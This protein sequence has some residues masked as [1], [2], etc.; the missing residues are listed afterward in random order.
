MITMNTITS[1]SLQ[2]KENLKRLVTYYKKFVIG[3]INR[4]WENNVNIIVAKITALL[5]LNQRHRA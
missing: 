3:K 4:N 1:F 5:N 2:N